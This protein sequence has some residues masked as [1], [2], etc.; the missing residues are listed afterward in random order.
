[1]VAEK[2]AVAPAIAQLRGELMTLLAR[3]EDEELLLEMFPHLQ[4]LYKSYMLEDMPP[5]VLKELEIAIEESYDESDT[6][7][8]EEVMKMAKQWAK[9]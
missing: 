8:H 3:V 4:K 7:P 9:E 2:I 6:I 5:H 1:M